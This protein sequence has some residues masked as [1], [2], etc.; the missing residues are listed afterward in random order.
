VTGAITPLEGDGPVPVEL[1]P[2]TGLLLSYPE[3][4]ARKRLEGDASPAPGLV[5]EPLPDTTPGIGKGEFVEGEITALDAGVEG[6]KWRATTRL[7]KSDV[8]TFMFMGFRWP[9]GVDLS[10]A[11]AL[12][13]KCQVPKGQRTPSKLLL[14]MVERGGGQYLADT[15]V[16]LGEPGTVTALIPLERFAPAGWSTDTNGQ[17]DLDSIGALSIGWGGY[18]GAEGEQVEFSLGQPA[19]IRLGLP[20]R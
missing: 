7:L 8:D 18:F 3:A 20:P 4:R 5:T 2:Y 19:A 9:E 13:V 15:N 1:A 11:L 6:L 16:S 14:I 17:L 12:S 10:G